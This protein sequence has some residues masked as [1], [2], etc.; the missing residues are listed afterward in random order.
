MVKI[1]MDWLEELEVKAEELDA[2][3][4]NQGEGGEVFTLEEEVGEVVDASSEENQKEARGD[5]D[6]VQVHGGVEGAG[7]TNEDAEVGQQS[8]MFNKDGSLLYNSE[9]PL[10]LEEMLAAGTSLDINLLLSLER[11]IFEEDL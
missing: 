5:G 3:E 10:V 4:V 6:V 1:E 2:G 8:G 9:F 11:R 7:V